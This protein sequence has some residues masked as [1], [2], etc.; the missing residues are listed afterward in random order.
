[1]ILAP[2]LGVQW[3]APHFVWQVRNELGR[4]LCPG[5][6]VDA[7]EKIDTGGYHVM[8]TLDVGMQ[9]TAEKWVYAAARAP[10]LKNTDTLPRQPRDPVRRTGPG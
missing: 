8:T 4:I 10:N 9:E 3:K 5:Q 6:P 7:C 2:Q 1:M